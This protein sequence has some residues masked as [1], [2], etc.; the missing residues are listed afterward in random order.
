MLDLPVGASDRGMTAIAARLA[1]RASSTAT[2]SSAAP[3]ADDHRRRPARPTRSPPPTLRTTLRQL[4]QRERRAGKPHHDR[5]PT[6]LRRTRYRRRCACPTS[7]MRAQTNKCGRWPDDLL[8]NA[9]EQALRQ[10]RLLLSEQPRRPDRQS[11]RSARAAQ[12]DADRC[13]EARRRD[14]RYTAERSGLDSDRKSTSDDG[15]I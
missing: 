8:A 10:F 14:R 7:A 12:A 5:P 13:R 9:R 3:V 1:R 15:R 2:T 6:R 4:R 11:G